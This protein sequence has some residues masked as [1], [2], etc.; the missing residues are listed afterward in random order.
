MTQLASGFL[1]FFPLEPSG[2]QFLGQRHVTQLQPIL[3]SNRRGTYR[4]LDRT[5]TP[6]FKPGATS[7]SEMNAMGD[8]LAS[9]R[10]PVSHRIRER[11]P[12]RAPGSMIDGRQDPEF[13]LTN[14]G[15][16]WR[17]SE[18]ERNRGAYRYRSRPR[19]TTTIT[20][21]RAHLKLVPIIP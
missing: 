21:A 12:G 3:G 20:T 11:L 2:E 13:L 5:C 14:H 18:K 19:R 15:K 16:R 6:L 7:T 17:K 4:A 8:F 1:F 9:P 10:S